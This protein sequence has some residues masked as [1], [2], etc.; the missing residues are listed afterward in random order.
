MLGGFSYKIS[1]EKFNALVTRAV[2][3]NRPLTK[4]K[5]LKR[6]HFP[7]DNREMESSRELCG[8]KTEYM[9]IMSTSWRVQ[10]W[11]RMQSVTA[12]S[13][14]PTRFIPAPPIPTYYSFQ[15]L[16]AFSFLRLKKSTEAS[17]SLWVV[18]FEEVHFHSEILWENIWP[19]ISKTLSFHFHLESF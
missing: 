15:S 9:P 3:S 11:G 19:A 12:Q 13:K 10:N 18:S 2:A 5:W 17:L 1:G 4:L 6:S 8:K 14:I 16:F 7:L